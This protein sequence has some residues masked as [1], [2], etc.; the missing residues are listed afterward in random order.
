MN[1]IRA[2]EAKEAPDVVLDNLPVN[3]ICAQVLFDTG[4]S[5]SFVSSS[6]AQR[7]KLSL[8]PLP[9]KLM[10]VSPGAKMATSTISHGNQIL[11][12]GHLF[13]AS[14]IALGKSDIDVIL[15]MDWLKANKAVIDCAEYSVSLPTSTGHIVYSPFQTP[16]V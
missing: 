8:D 7:H 15:G 12:G 11:I 14:F 5:H 2:E 4:A 10:V 6:F 16:S 3:S 9:N 13:L 1:H